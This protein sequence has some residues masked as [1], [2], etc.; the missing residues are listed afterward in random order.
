MTNNIVCERLTFQIHPSEFVKDFIQADRE[1]WDPWL[2]RQP[3]FIKKVSEIK[4]NGQVELLIFW[5]GLDSMKKA[6]LKKEEME[7]VD[8][9]LR[10]RAPGYYR[11]VLSTSQN[12]NT[13]WPFSS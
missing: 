4:G 3:G 12:L 1:V 6:S 10:M 13:N 9:L 5:R 7:V 11:L 8:K 2:R